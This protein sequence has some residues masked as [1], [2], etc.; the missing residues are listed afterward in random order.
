MKI[1]KT[2]PEALKLLW[3]EKILLKPKTYKLIDEEL[4]RRGYNFQEKNLMMALKSA[5]FL[6]RKGSKGQ[7][8]YVQKHPYIEEGRNEE[9]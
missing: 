6:T 2:A 8:Q 3:E 4:E 5:K 1:A 7:Y 9:L